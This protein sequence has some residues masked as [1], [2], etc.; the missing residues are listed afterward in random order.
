M[1]DIRIASI[2]QFQDQVPEGNMLI[3]FLAGIQMA[4]AYPEWAQGYLSLM[5]LTPLP[6]DARQEILDALPV[7]MPT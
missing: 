5:N 2:A 7:S 6:D 3:G 4:F 1:T